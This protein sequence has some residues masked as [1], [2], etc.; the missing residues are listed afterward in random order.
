MN[1]NCGGLRR[2]HHCVPI[3]S[4]FIF[5]DDRYKRSLPGPLLGT[6][7]FWVLHSRRLPG[8][9]AADL[10]LGIPIRVWYDPNGT[11]RQQLADSRPCHGGWDQPDTRGS[12]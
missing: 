2:D 5:A 9:S 6:E 12:S 8:P 7:D 4:D 3:T 10:E 1:T 11:P